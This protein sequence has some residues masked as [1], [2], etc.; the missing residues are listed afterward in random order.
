M[1]SDR[2][3]V[4]E[5]ETIVAEV[6]ARYLD[7][8][9][10]DVR[11]V[12]DFQPHLVVLDLML[13]GIDSMGV[14]KRIRGEAATPIIMLTARREEDDKLD[15]LDSGADDYVTKPFSPRELAARVC[16]AAAVGSRPSSVPAS[17]SRPRSCSRRGSRAMSPSP[18]S[19]SPSSS[20][21]RAWA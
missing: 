1:P 21:A 7:R 20:P 17:S 9:G 10:Q 16:S 6:I 19:P 4:V 12:H 2:I 14:C 5:D 13:P 18:T 8:D 3:L 15:G 11:V